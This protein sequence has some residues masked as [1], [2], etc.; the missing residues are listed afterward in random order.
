MAAAASEAV[1]KDAE[2]TDAAEVAEVLTD[3][4][5]RLQA[6]ADKDAE[7]HQ[8]QACTMLAAQLPATL[9]ASLSQVLNKDMTCLDVLRRRTSDGQETF[10]IL[11]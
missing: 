6:A 1:A 4:L 9:Q 3:E 7:Q 10:P 5:E 11:L 2:L 8:R